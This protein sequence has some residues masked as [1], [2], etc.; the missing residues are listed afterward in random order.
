MGW[1]NQLHLQR[2]AMGI[3]AT[4]GP[5]HRE[6]TLTASVRASKAKVAVLDLAP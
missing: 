5:L 2:N 4:G 6:Q 1:A 3:D